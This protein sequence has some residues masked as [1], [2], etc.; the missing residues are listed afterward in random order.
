MADIKENYHIEVFDVLPTA[1]ILNPTMSSEIKAFKKR[2]S[3]LHIGHGMYPLE[4]IPEKH[5]IKNQWIVKPEG[6]NRG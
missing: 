2:F 3:D 5:C 4:N 6:L 1:Y